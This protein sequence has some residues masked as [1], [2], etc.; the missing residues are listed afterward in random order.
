MN[1]SP[2]MSGRSIR[3]V[4]TTF[5]LA[6]TAFTVAAANRAVPGT[7]PTIADAVA[8]AQPGDHILVGPGVYQENVVSTVA[9]LQF[10]GKGAIWDGTLVNGTAGVCLTAT[11]DGVVVQGFIFRAGQ[12][13]AAQVQLTGAGCRVLNCSSRGP[14][15]RFLKITGNSALVDACTLYAVNSGAI[16][17]IGDNAT[18]R[19]VKSR[20][21]DD[22]VIGIT[23]NGA[24]VTSCIMS[25]NEDGA[26][27]SI[28][29]HHALVNLN[30]F[31]DCDSGI[32]V[33]GTNAIVTKNKALNGGS[34]FI[35]VNSGDNAIVERNISTAGGGISVSGDAVAVR[36]NSMRSMR[37]DASGLTVNGATDAGGAVVENNIMKDIAANGLSVGINN[38][39]IRGN[40]VTGSGTESGESACRVS[41]SGNRLTNNVVI[42][43]GTHGFN[44]TGANNMFVRCTAIDSA[45]DGFHI[46]G[47]GNT[48]LICDAM[49]CTGEGL[50]NGGANT[51]VLDCAFKK[52]RLDVA[53]DGTFANAATFTSDNSFST[54]GPSQLPQV[55]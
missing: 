53:N 41:G 9:N 1:Y 14:S 40:R 16:E 49:L 35:S 2:H 36:G 30:S 33:T 23:G 45:A 11:G 12:A 37:N 19:K 51:T 26:S 21:G 22:S 10:I 29:G 15:A 3:N 20:Q 46:T 55:D 5:L 8:A 4:A 54:G 39:V 28:V 50:D 17:I 18:V 44:I 42:G 47:S 25:L 52:N 24:T 34:S 6:V 31:V 27:I 7:H 13:N 32:S 43:G 48:L 38:A